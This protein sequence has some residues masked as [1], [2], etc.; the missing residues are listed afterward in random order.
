MLPKLSA[1][2][3][4]LPATYLDNRLSAAKAREVRHIECRIFPRCTHY[5]STVLLA[6]PTD[7]PNVLTVCLSVCLSSRFFAIG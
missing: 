1:L 5:M 2:S 6:L 3:F 4:L 7:S